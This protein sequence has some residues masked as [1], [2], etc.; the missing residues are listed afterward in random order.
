MGIPSEVIRSSLD[1]Y[2]AFFSAALRHVV[3]DSW[4]V[5]RVFDFFASWFSPL[6]FEQLQRKTAFLLAMASSKRPSELSSIR[7]SSAFMVIDEE[8]ARFLPSRRSKMTLT[9]RFGEAFSI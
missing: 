6:S 4:N 8:K 9:I 2:R 5:G 3:S 7:C 1:S